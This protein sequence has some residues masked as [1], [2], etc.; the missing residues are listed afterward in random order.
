MVEIRIDYQGELHC[1]AVHG[2]SGDRLSTDAP[3]D[4]QGRGEAFSP[5]DLVAAALGTCMATIMGIVA[6]RKEVALDGMKV[7]VGK[8]MS[9][10]TPRRIARLD[11]EI[12]VPLPADHPD[13]SLLEAAALGCPVKH[14]LHPEI[15]VVMDWKWEG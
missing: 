1:E 11:V 14:S 8:T 15:A 10:D 6:R 13:R 2:P 9:A 4:N 3:V 12:L 5:T 7:R